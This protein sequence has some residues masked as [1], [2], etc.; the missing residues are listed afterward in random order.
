MQSTFGV[1]M[2]A[3][4]NNQP[5][6]LEL[7]QM[8]G[9]FIDHRKAVIVRRTR[10]ELRQAEARRTSWRATASPWITSTR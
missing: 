8:I 7:K 6:V 2:L 5:R 4:V 3:L 10:F 1:I 9:H